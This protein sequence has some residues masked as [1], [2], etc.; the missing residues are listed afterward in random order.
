MKSQIKKFR[1]KDFWLKNFPK[2]LAIYWLAVFLILGILGYQIVKAKSPANLFPSLPADFLSSLKTNIPPTF[3]TDSSLD[4]CDQDGDGL[5][6][7]E[8]DIF[9]TDAENKD[10]D[11]DGYED[12][13]EVQNGF[14]PNG[15]GRPQSTLIIPKLGVSAPLLFPQNNSESSILE[16]LKSGIIRY[17]GSAFPGQA[18]NSIIFGHSSDYFWRSGNFKRVFSGLNNLEDGDE[19]IIEL[20]YVS[21]FKKVLKFQVYAKEILWPIDQRIFKASDKSELTLVTCWPLNTSLKRLVV[22]AQGVK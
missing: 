19:I 14:E 1:Q 17:P 6:N 22:R 20:A 7:E 2:I 4:P 11:G 5:K 9:G 10:T 15:P 21:G 16:E 18:A 3:P 12:G 13:K 8:E